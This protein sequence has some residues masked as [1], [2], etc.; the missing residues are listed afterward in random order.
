MPGPDAIDLGFLCN[1]SFCL[2]GVMFG[3]QWTQIVFPVFAAVL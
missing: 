3:E 1:V 2:F